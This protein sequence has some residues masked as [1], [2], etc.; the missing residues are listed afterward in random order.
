MKQAKKTPSILSYVEE[1]T[2]RGRF[3]GETLPDDPAPALPRPL[4]E[5]DA[6]FY[7]TEVPPD[8][9]SAK[10]I[11]RSFMQ[12]MAIP[13]A[14]QRKLLYGQLASSFFVSL[15]D[16]LMAEIRM[17]PLNEKRTLAF[18]EELLYFSPHREPV[19]FALLLYSL[20]DVKKVRQDKDLWQ[21]LVTLAK[22]EEFTYFFFKAFG[23][24]PQKDAWAILRATRGWGRICALN[25]AEFKTKEKQLWLIRHARDLTV[26][27]PPIT[28][29]MIIDSRLSEVLGQENI[30]AEIY[31]GAQL[32]LNGFLVLLG[33]H[34]PDVI[35]EHCNVRLINLPQLL[36]DFLRHAE[37][38]A[39]GP[40]ELVDINVMRALLSALSEK[41]FLLTANECH[42]LI[43]ACDALIYK[44]DWTE[45]ITKGLFKGGRVNYAICDFAEG[46]GID[47]W[48]GL[49]MYYKKHPESTPVI[50]YLFGYDEGRNDCAL[51]AVTKNLPAYMYDQDALM[52]PLH[53]L[54]YHPGK[55][56]EIIV[57]ALLS[58]YDLPR[59]AACTILTDWGSEY[60]TIR[61]RNA[62]K[63]AREMS[64]HPA[65]H[66]RIDAL[67][68]GTAE[69]L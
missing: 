31:A 36:K 16:P 65:I 1:H 13:A 48:P 22:C 41:P 63:K 43:A 7:A 55:G 29:K 54:K 21:D 5:A 12:F 6:N 62:L 23:K 57:A 39:A 38:F 27:Y 4:G 66:E 30:D 67:L 68:A 52:A 34:V 25:F 26:E 59:G 3:K 19:K 60:I 2:V 28:A 40:E 61:M 10:K 18:A 45:E 50:P 20:F 15:S 37:K 51:A 35:E 14:A 33:Q 69:L 46:L 64:G 44:K 58:S 11:A 24:V 32:I 9:L 47:I 17:M 42:L 8:L 56:E 53:Y 49:Y